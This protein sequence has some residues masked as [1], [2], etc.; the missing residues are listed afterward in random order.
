MSKLKA[1]VRT[2]TNIVAIAFMLGIFASMLFAL[3]LVMQ[4]PKKGLASSEAAGWV[5]AIG[6]VIAIASGFALANRQA[7]SAAAL[8]KRERLEEDVERLLSAFAV[9]AHAKEIIDEAFTNMSNKGSF[10]GYFLV[11]SY[12]LDFH[13]GK[14]AIELIPLHELRSTEMIKG[15]LGVQNCLASAYRL[16]EFGRENPHLDNQNIDEWFAQV[17][18]FRLAS[19]D[20]FE[21]V[22]NGVDRAR[23]L[24]SQET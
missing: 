17:E 15:V 12:Y 20:A 6:S 10:M 8:A 7:Q 18:E 5:Q 23:A 4:D 14:R 1:A 21:R 19:E 24:L 22:S 9:V 2:T 13:G 11:S 16:T 3:R